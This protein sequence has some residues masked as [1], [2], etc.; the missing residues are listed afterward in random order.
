MDEF[1]GIAIL[2]LAL[3]VFILGI[4]LV[5]ERRRISRLLVKAGATGVEFSRSSCAS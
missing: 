1:A 4:S 2:V 5:T 3:V